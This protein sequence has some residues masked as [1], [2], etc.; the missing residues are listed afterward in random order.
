M[1]Q[2]RVSLNGEQCDRVTSQTD[3]HGHL[4][5][6]GETV[7][8]LGRVSSLARR[9]HT[10]LYPRKIELARV[11]GLVPRGARVEARW[12]SHGD[13]EVDRN[14]TKEFYSGT[15]CEPQPPCPITGRY[16]VHRPTTS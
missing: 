15:D 11:T 12:L 9:I 16:M 4:G 13:P 3:S 2:P 1:L 8:L 14:Y 7:H 5:S 10:E 6:Y